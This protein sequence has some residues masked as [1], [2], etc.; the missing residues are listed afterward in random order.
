MLYEVITPKAPR[1]RRWLGLGVVVLLAASLALPALEWVV[2]KMLP[3]DNKSEFQVMVELP[4][5]SPV[6]Q[7]QA[8][9]AQLADEVSQEPEVT[10]V[11]LYAGTSAPSYNFV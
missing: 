2:L 3:F 4:E 9:L 6:E 7:T 1:A 10:D 8:L 5:G 11:Q